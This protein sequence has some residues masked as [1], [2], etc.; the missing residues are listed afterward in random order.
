MRIDPRFMSL[1]IATFIALATSSSR[2]D[3]VF[4][5]DFDD[6]TLTTDPL[7]LTTS[8]SGSSF[9]SSVSSQSAS[10]A[11]TARTLSPADPFGAGNQFLEFIDGNDATATMRGVLTAAITGTGFTVSFDFYDPTS[12]TTRLGDAVTRG[13]RMYL[14]SSN[15]TATG[16]RTIDM[17]L[18]NGI[19]RGLN[20]NNGSNVDAGTYTEG[21]MH[22]VVLVGNLSNA[23]I[24]YFMGGAQSVAPGAYDIYID[25]NLLANGNDMPFRNPTVNSIASISFSG[26]GPTTVSETYFDNIVVDNSVPIPEPS[27]IML[28]AIATGSLGLRK[29]HR[30]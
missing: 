13:G 16:D 29:S 6:I 30:R 9:T 28:L 24:D 19:L 18:F 21:G 4:S 12:A 26:A 27:A 7:P 17:D 3:I 8:T 5:E 11:I 20:V 15:S 22:S 10:T 2:A 25:G 23:P 1:C 14:A